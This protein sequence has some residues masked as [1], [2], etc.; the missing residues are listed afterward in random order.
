LREGNAVED[1]FN[2]SLTVIGGTNKKGIDML[3]EIYNNVPGTKKVVEIRVAETIKL[4]NNSFHALKVAFANEI[5]NVAKALGINTNELFEIF[6][7]D[8]KLNI[9]DAYLKPGF[10]YGGSCLPK[11]L[12][13]L[14]LIAHDN[15]LDTPVLNSIE[16]SNQHQIER[17]IKLIESFNRNNIGFWGISFKEGTDDLRNSPVVQVAERI[18][19][20]GY[21][22]YLFD[23]AVNESQLIGANKYYIENVFPHFKQLLLK[24]FDEFLNN[25]EILII[26]KRG[27]KQEFNKI[28][29][30]DKLQILDLK[31]IQELKS[32]KNYYGFNW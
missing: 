25:I 15:Y 10:A 19:G 23:E 20:K 29:N 1:F 16:R 5:G 7:L 32:H 14:T 17:A 4:L 8:R 28:F 18:M 26:N 2:P 13:A 12:R 9:S 11:D 30:K 24:N 27:S 6:L 31:G 22:T 3:L 21:N